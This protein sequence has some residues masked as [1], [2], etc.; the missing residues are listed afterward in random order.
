[1]I[2]LL[3]SAMQDVVGRGTGKQARILN[4][5]DLAGKT[6]TSNDQH[7]GWFSGFNQNIIAVVW[8]GY[9]AP[10][11]LGEYGARAALPIWIDFMRAALADTPETSLK[12]PE[13]IIS[14]RID[15]LTGLR[16]P[17]THQPSIFE[18][19]RAGNEPPMENEGGNTESNQSESQK[20]SDPS[21]GDLY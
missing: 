14:V 11:S 19:F 3:D 13:G 7:D 18:I 12:R 17:A 9:D 21:L 4:R 6:G 5:Q 20:N 10:K 1:M 8:V 16:V 15:P 2:Y